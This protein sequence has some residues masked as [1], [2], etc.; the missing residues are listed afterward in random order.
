MGCLIA[1]SQFL[2][3][4]PIHIGSFA[5]NNLQL[6]A[7]YASTPHCIYNSCA[8]LNK[9]AHFSWSQSAQVVGLRSSVGRCV[10][11]Y[12]SLLHCVAV[13]CAAAQPIGLFFKYTGVE[14]WGVC[15]LCVHIFVCALLRARLPSCACMCVCMCVFACPCVCVSPVPLLFTFS[16]SRGTS[17]PPPP[18]PLPPAV[19]H[20]DNVLFDWYVCILWATWLIHMCD[21]THVCVCHDSCI[22]V[23][24]VCLYAVCDMAH[25]YGC[26]DSYT[27]VPW[28]IY[29]GDMT[30]VSVC[31]E[32]FIC[33]TWLMYVC[34]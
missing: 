5:E 30:H 6:K 25:L 31:H 27:R 3:K 33:V 29:V 17:A 15:S 8:D 34:I 24:Y 7:S 12:R 23:T 28:L 4:S 19:T 22:R 32:S 20:S 26:H 21:T 2:R 9:R 11:M 14:L 18:P 1:T 16:V 13:P 10:G